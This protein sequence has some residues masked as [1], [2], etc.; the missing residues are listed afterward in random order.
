[1][2]QL[3]IIP[4]YK[5]QIDETEK[6]SLNQCLTI[7]KKYPICFVTFKEL[8]LTNYQTICY[9]YNIKPI[10]EYF[11]KK[12]FQN[13]LNGYNE[14][15]LSKN[16]YKRFLEYTYIL[17]YQLDA[18]VFQDDIEY[19][20]KKDYT[21]IGGPIFTGYRNCNN[22]ST[23]T[24]FMNGGLS[25]RKTKDM[26]TLINDNIKIEYF[27]QEYEQKNI[28]NKIKAIIKIIF[29]RINNYSINK[30][31]KNEDLLLSNILIENI[32]AFNRRPKILKSFLN[33]RE[34]N[35]NIPNF[36]ETYKFSFD[37]NVE[38]LFKLSDNKLPSFCHSFHRAD[39][40][41]FWKQFIDFKT[42]K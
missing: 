33:A 40:R 25:L 29:G 30:K 14:L 15:M 24:G 17:I 42:T 18:F 36:E 38:Y 12:Y 23:Y 13:G 41:T 5:I 26:Y 6:L 3:I 21:F 20:C 19:W 16:F 7:L 9:N 34:T 27:E 8:D 35:Y 37:E 4:I 28:L 11:D 39:K 31:Y 2:Q 1:M 10:I 22:N 32:K